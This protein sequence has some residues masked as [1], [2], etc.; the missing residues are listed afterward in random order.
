MLIKKL[1]NPAKKNVSRN[2]L[3]NQE[4]LKLY[5]NLSTHGL[6]SLIVEVLKRENKY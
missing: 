4:P 5:F 1:S 3:F 6:F 2:F